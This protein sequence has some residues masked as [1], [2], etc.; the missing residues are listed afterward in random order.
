M[1]KSGL[2]MSAM[3]SKVSEE[4]KLQIGG[5]QRG[6]SF[7]S[8]GEALKTLTFI[9]PSQSKTNKPPTGMIPG[10][11]SSNQKPLISG[12]QSSNARSPQKRKPALADIFKAQIASGKVDLSN[13][14]K[15]QI[16]SNLTHFIHRLERHPF[17][18]AL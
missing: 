2:A 16:Y 9:K 4:K 15:Y 18:P 8:E 7:N 10:L 13:K 1:Q 5:H 14:S 3:K 12:T 11:S 17:L 6:N